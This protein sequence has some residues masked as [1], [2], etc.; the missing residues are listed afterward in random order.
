[1]VEYME[2]E[3]P[4]G[5]LFK[6]HVKNEQDLEGFGMLL[7]VPNKLLFIG[8]ISRDTSCFEGPCHI[9]DLSGEGTLY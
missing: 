4:N 6:G 9:Y 5:D 2:L 8:N 1:M 3:F 7:K